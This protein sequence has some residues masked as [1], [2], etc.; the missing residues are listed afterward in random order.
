MSG[1][2]K[3]A[4]AGRPS[5]QVEVFDKETNLTTTYDS[6]SAAAIALEIPQS[7]ISMYFCRKNPKPCK[8]KYIFKK[9]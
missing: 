4:G 2:N 3:P 8:G 1:C 6:F 9:F 5:Q 7:T